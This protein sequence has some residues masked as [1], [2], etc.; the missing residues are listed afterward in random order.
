[1]DIVA[2][3]LIDI[4][5]PPPFCSIAVCTARKSQAYFI[6]LS[7]R[8]SVTDAVCIY[9]HFS[10]SRLGMGG[11]QSPISFC[12]YVVALSINRASNAWDRMQE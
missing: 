4:V 2:V 7:P 5:F 8:L 3:W 1:M 12:L 10:V 11:I 6:V 9:F